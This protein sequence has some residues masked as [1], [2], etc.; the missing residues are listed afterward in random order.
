MVFLVGFFFVCDT[1]HIRVESISKKK[2]LFAIS[3]NHLLKRRQI[4]FENVPIKAIPSSAVMCCPSELKNHHEESTQTQ[5]EVAIAFQNQE[6][7][8]PSRYAHFQ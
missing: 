5:N 7:K 6:K 4:P 8:H 2:S 1:C 3:A